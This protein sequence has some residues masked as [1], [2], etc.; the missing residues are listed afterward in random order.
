M[1]LNFE[2]PYLKRSAGLRVVWE[3][4]ARNTYVLNQMKAVKV[5]KTKAHFLLI[6]HACERQ[7]CGSFYYHFYADDSQIS[8]PGCNFFPKFPTLTAPLHIQLLN[9]NFLSDSTNS[10]GIHLPLQTCCTYDFSSFSPLLGIE[11]LASPLMF[12]FL[13]IS[14]AQEREALR[15]TCSGVIILSPVIETMLQAIYMVYRCHRYALD[16]C[17]PWKMQESQLIMGQSVHIK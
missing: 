8:L 3:I 9:V 17:M 11:T 7:A 10:K 4:T 14:Q 16:S 13:S 1:G 12:P 6:L 2:D 15:S 5:Q